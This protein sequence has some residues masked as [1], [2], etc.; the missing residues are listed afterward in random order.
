MT[1]ATEILALDQE[2]FSAA[3]RTSPMI[4]ERPA[5]TVITSSRS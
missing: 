5:T 4:S 1:L 2:Q 3:F